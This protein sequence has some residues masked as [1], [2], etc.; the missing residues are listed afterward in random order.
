MCAFAP[1]IYA[2]LGVT[3]ASGRQMMLKL[4]MLVALIV[5][6][7]ICGSAS[8]HKMSNGT[9]ADCLTAF[10]ASYHT[11]YNHDHGDVII[12]SDATADFIEK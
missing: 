6:T 1:V 7:M 9:H 3:I 5:E 8:T 12:S 4:V 11:E 10:A 2:S